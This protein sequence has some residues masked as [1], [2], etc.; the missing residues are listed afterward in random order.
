VSSRDQSSTQ[1]LTLAMALK[2]SMVF[3]SG[4]SGLSHA[5]KAST[6]KVGIHRGKK[7]LPHKGMSGA[8]TTP[9]V[10]DLFGSTS[11]SSEDEAI[12]PA[13][14]PHRKH[15]RKSPPKTFRMPYD[16]PPVKG[17][18]IQRCSI[19]FYFLCLLY[20]TFLLSADDL[21]LAGVF[22]DGGAKESGRQEVCTT[23]FPS[24]REPPTDSKSA[25]PRDTGVLDIAL[26]LGHMGTVNYDV[27][28][29]L[30]VECLQYMS[31]TMFAIP[32]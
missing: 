31:S 22:V 17:T 4:S 25:T 12:A 20:L 32:Y 10:L 26:V 11:S 14:V 13:L 15:R 28:C 18:S 29:G 21:Q 6:A 30:L 1:E 16:V 27:V 24:S 19:S 9:K 23:K 7:L 8:G 3:S 2:L 5:E